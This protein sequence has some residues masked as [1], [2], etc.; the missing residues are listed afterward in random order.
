MG[1]RFAGGIAPG[2]MPPLHRYFGNPGLS[3]M[4]RL[5]FGAPVGDFYCGL[6]AFRRDALSKLNLQSPGMEL[7][8]EMVAK[9]ALYGL[10]HRRGPDDALAR[11]AQPPA[12][13]AHLARRLAARCGSSS[14]TA[15]AGC[16]SIRA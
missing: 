9:A 5:F 6:R 3:W 2:A 8:V 12:A 11:P 4:G 16:S 7:G 15:R 13:P 10:R 14:S 1:N